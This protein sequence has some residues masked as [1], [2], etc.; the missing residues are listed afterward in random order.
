[1]GQHT[2][3]ILFC[4]AQFILAAA[5]IV[6]M[7]VRSSKAQVIV[8]EHT[9]EIESL[10]KSRHEHGNILSALQVEVKNLG[11]RLTRSGNGGKH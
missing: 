3:F 9:E 4:A 2:P 10:R 6:A 1:M 7:H 8:D 11:D 5:A